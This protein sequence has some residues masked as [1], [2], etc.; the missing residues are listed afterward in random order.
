ML[1]RFRVDRFGC[2]KWYT[3]DGHISNAPDTGVTV[4]TGLEREPGGNV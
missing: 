3:L 2:T 1:Y 4:K